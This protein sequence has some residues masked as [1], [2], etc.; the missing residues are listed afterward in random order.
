MERK[1]WISGTNRGVKP[2]EIT[3]QYG[4]GLYSEKYQLKA[5]QPQ[6]KSFIKKYGQIPHIDHIGSAHNPKELD[7]T[8]AL[9]SK[10]TR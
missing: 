5:V 8:V 9:A 6:S 1:R 7:T 2:A 10:V 3:L 4:Y